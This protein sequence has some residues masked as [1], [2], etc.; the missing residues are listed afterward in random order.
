MVRRGER[1]LGDVAEVGAQQRGS[2]RVGERA[3]FERRKPR[4][5]L[6]TTST[7]QRATASA[8]AAAAQ[9]ASSGTVAAAWPQG[10]VADRRHRRIG[11]HRPAQQVF[12]HRQVGGPGRNGHR[13]V[14]RPP[15]VAAELGG[16]E[17]LCAHLVN[18]RTAS[19][20]CGCE[21]NPDSLSTVVSLCPAVTTTGE[22]S[23]NA[24]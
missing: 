10:G 5:W 14:Q 16:A 2:Q 11:W 7:G 1:K 13:G 21:Q 3:Q 20:R 8:A 15:Q 12:R 17:R 23:W 22:E 4:A 9:L 19:G 6:P 24:L 18:G